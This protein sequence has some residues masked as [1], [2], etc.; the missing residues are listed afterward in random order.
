MET[1]D[2]S[3]IFLLWKNKTKQTKQ[4]VIS[5]AVVLNQEAKAH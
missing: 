4:T 3:Q 2:Y 1:S 5:I